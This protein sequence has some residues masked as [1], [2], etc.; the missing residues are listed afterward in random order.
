MLNYT[1]KCCLYGFFFFL[2]VFARQIASGTR[3]LLFLLT[4][5]HT[6]TRT[7]THTHTHTRTHTHT[8]THPHAHSHTHTH[9]HTHTVT[10]VSTSSSRPHLTSFP[11]VAP[12]VQTKGQGGQEGGGRERGSHGQVLSNDSISVRVC[13]FVGIVCGIGVGMG[14]AGGHDSISMAPPT[15]GHKTMT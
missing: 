9:T 8:H 12:V 13:Y 5:T 14:G 10:Q 3:K 4:H 6:H 7:H 15:K 2:L 1:L 11:S